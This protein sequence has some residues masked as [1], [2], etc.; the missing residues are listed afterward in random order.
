MNAISL[1]RNVR[2]ISLSRDVRITRR[3]LQIALGLLWLLDGGQQLPRFMLRTSFA[4]QILDPVAAGQPHFVA[5]PVHWAANLIAAHPVAWDVPFAL[6]QLL[7]GLGLLFPRTAKLALAASIPWS[8]GVWFFGEGLSGLAS[9]HASLLTGAPGSVFLYGVL[10]LAAWPR[11]DPSQEAPARWLPLAWAV[12]W[13]GGA[14]FQALPGQN[15]GA[16]VA[17]AINTGAPG[18]PGR[19]DASVAGWITRHGTLVVVALVVAEALIGLGALYRRSRGPAVAAGFALAL[20]IWVVGQDFGL[21]YTGQ[22][23]DP[24]TAPI[25]ALMAIVILGARWALVGAPVRAGGGVQARSL[26][27]ARRRVGGEAI[28]WAETQKPRVAR[29]LRRNRISS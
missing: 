15:N 21:L 13:V 23:T 25:I 6:A 2:A 4:R 16:D 27:P 12:I 18:W 20:A 10:A 19:L 1:S 14:I 28:A 22:A 9:G 3:H 5:G 29:V 7:I 11:R 8:L 17:G 26:G 24:N